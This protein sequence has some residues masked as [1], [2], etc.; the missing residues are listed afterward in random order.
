MTRSAIPING[1]AFPGTVLVTGA[2]AIGGAWTDGS[3]LGGAVAAST[4]IVGKYNPA[5]TIKFT[6]P[7]SGSSP[8]ATI[9]QTLG[10]NVDLS[11]CDS[12][13][14]AMYV[15]PEQWNLS[16]SIAFTLILS[17]DVGGFTNYYTAAFNPQRP[18]WNFFQK[19]T[20]T[21]PQAWTVGAGA[22]SWSTIRTVR[23]RVTGEAT[24]PKTVYFDG[25]VGGQRGR[26]KICF[27]FD[28]C[29]ITQY[30]AAYPILTSSNIKATFFCKSNLDEGGTLNSFG[31]SASFFTV[32]NG[33]E[34]I[35]AGHEF[36]Y[37]G[38][39]HAGSIGNWADFADPYPKIRTS[40]DYVNQLGLTAVGPYA[41]YPNGDYGSGYYLGTAVAKPS[42]V[43]AAVTRAGIVAC[44][45]VATY[46]TT[47]GI[48]FSPSSLVGAGEKRVIPSVN[49]E[50]TI[51][52]AQAKAL[53]D[54]V[55]K[56]GESFVMCFH[57]LAGAPGVVTWATTDFQSLCDYVVRMRGLGLVDTV[58]FSD[59]IHQCGL[60]ATNRALD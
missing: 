56:T 23:V 17:S 59:L 44:R 31:P 53:V 11:K 39:H 34:L 41:A 12:V 16:T 42:D 49:M 58:K 15:S 55:I 54:Q 6:T 3:T 33:N 45:G 7:A 46:T 19:S 30:S 26:P 4:D 18:G 5:Q 32:E 43:L 60:D 38:A 2:G 29:D 48:L 8:T 36:Q 22:P 13:G 52:L 40:I 37:H 10:A 35:A 50:S 21:G 51:T 57:V 14:V 27:T 1:A 20:N 25:I 28:D 9:T 47:N 24:G